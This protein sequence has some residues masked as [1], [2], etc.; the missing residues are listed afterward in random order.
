MEHKSKENVEGQT[1]TSPGVRIFAP[2]N[3]TSGRWMWPSAGAALT[4][5]AALRAARLSFTHDEALRYN[6]V[7]GDTHP[8]QTANH[9]Y[10]NTRAMDFCSGLLGVSEGSLRAGSVFA[11]VLYLA[12]VF[13]G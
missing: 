3:K 2:M 11:F 9:Q 7:P 6:I 4:A 12:A 8:A 5:Y 10:L 13:Y 1:K